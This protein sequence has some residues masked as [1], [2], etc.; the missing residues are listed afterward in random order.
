MLPRSR[1]R[2]WSPMAWRTTCSR[3]SASRTRRGARPR[4]RAAWCRRSGPS[5]QTPPGRSEG[6]LALRHVFAQGVCKTLSDA[7]AMRRFQECK[8]LLGRPFWTRHG[9]STYS[10]LFDAFRNV[11]LFW[12]LSGTHH[13]FTDAFWSVQF[14]LGPPEVP[15]DPRRG[16]ERRSGHRRFAE[17]LPGGLQLRARRRSLRP[18]HRCACPRQ[19]LRAREIGGHQKSR[20]FV[21]GI[22]NQHVDSVVSWPLCAPQVRQAS[23]SRSQTRPLLTCPG[24]PSKLVT[25]MM[26]V[27][28]CRTP[29]SGTWTT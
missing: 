24:A 10:M 3:V 17:L 23:T 5:S 4:H 29:G 6:K 16:A 13:I 1:S 28:L 18:Q 25:W 14:T 7:L 20:S 9:D 15:G 2:F 27:R 21:H 26:Y 11:R 12:T 19:R 8:P 22:R